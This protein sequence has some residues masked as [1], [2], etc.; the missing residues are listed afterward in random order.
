[1]LSPAYSGHYDPLAPLMRADGGDY[2][3]YRLLTTATG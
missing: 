3:I 2:L 1:M